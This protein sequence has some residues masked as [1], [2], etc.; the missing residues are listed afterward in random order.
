MITAAERRAKIDKLKR[1]REIKEAEKKRREE[2]KADAAT[3]K[4]TSN[5]LIET[6]LKKTT[7]AKD[8]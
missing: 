2:E 4:K 7:E 6:I 3:N 1:D 8:K 5:D